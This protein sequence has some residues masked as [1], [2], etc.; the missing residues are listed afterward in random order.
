MLW[1]SL[2][3][4]VLLPGNFSFWVRSL[5]CISMGAYVLVLV[6]IPNAVRM[7]SYW[8]ALRGTRSTRDSIQTTLSLLRF[9]EFFTP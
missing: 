4:S 3:C 9:F 5:A 1:A 7:Y 6:A 2:A 8:C